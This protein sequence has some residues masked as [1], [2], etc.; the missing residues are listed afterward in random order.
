[1]ALRRGGTSQR[2][3]ARGPRRKTS[4]ELGPGGTATTSV[5]ASV[6]GFLGS[7]VSLVSG[8]AATTVVRI[9]GQFDIY[10]TLATA[11]NDGF[12]GAIGIGLATTQA[13]AAGIA[14]VPT[15]ITD[16]GDENWLFWHVVSVH[17]PQA[18]SVA[19]ARS[20][21][22]S[23]I[24]DSKAMR[25]FEDGMSLYAAFELVEIPAASAEMFF[26]SRMLLKLP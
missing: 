6:A 18:S 22:Q 9:R 21:F 26:D 7:A 20:S 11:A 3:F 1:M 2:T 16:A 23:L 14:S 15:P 5:S 12:Q 17:N 24:V 19:F 10:M 25:K 4:W 8:V 13:V